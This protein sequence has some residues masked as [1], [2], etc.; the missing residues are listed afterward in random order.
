MTQTPLTAAS[1]PKPPN[2]M[3]ILTQFGSGAHLGK[4]AVHLSAT[5]D[6]P[7]TIHY[8]LLMHLQP[9]S[10]PSEPMHSQSEQLRV[11]NP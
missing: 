7:F 8:S 6:G 3:T 2:E 1:C 11:G 10:I 5:D 9:L 4:L